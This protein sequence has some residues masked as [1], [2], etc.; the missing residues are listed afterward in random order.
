[1]RLLPTNARRDTLIFKQT[2]FEDDLENPIELILPPRLSFPSGATS[3]TSPVLSIDT[4]GG[5]KPSRRAVRVRP[6]SLASLNGG[7][8]L[9]SIPASPSTPWGDA[10]PSSYRLNGKGAVFDSPAGEFQLDEQ[11]HQNVKPV[12]HFPKPASGPS[13]ADPRMQSHAIPPRSN[14]LSPLVGQRKHR[15]S[16][17]M[18]GK[19]TNGWRTHKKSLSNSESSQ[20]IFNQTNDKPHRLGPD[21]AQM[22]ATRSPASPTFVS[23]GLIKVKSI[24]AEPQFPSVEHVKTHGAIRESQRPEVGII[25]SQ[26][27]AQRKSGSDSGDQSANSSVDQKVLPK[28][29]NGGE[30]KSVSRPRRGFRDF[31]KAL[32]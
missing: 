22:I 21:S 31:F 29:E 10:A 4:S 23:N 16:L 8:L 9:P 19:I 32:G 1:M 28:S 13:T 3:P 17:S 14:G 12:S 5:L 24:S 6:S 26:S 25:H 2:T 18:P 11:E 30:A 20:R 15:K 7:P 27:F